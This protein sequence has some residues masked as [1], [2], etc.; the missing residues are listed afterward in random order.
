MRTSADGDQDALALKD[1]NIAGVGGDLDAMRIE[2]ARGAECGLHRVAGELMLQHIDLVV[3][4]HVQTRHQVLGGDVLLHP[5][6][7]PVEAAL[8]PAGEVEH[9]FPQRLGRDGA[10]VHRDA[11]DATTL[12]HHEDGPAELGRLD[13]GTATGGSAADDDEVDCVHGLEDWR[14]PGRRVYRN[15]GVIEPARRLEL[16]VTSRRR[17]VLLPSL[18]IG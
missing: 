16:E 1:A 17:K 15:R 4:R 9:G 13:R 12:L 6:G 10:G 7:T 2:E 11:A 3:E 8:A 5:I 18:A 14:K